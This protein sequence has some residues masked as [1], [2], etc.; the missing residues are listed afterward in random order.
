MELI[1]TGWTDEARAASLATRRAKAEARQRKREEMFERQHRDAG[2]NFVENWYPRGRDGGYEDPH[3][4]ETSADAPYGYVEGTKEP[5]KEPLYD[6]YGRPIVPRPKE[7][8]APG[9]MFSSKR[10]R[11]AKRDRLREWL[12]RVKAAEKEWG[13][14][15][16]KKEWMDKHPEATESDWEAYD[17][18]R[19]EEWKKRNPRS[20]AVDSRTGN[21]SGDRTG[22]CGPTKGNQRVMNTLILNRETFEMPNDGWYQI[23][24][25]GEF[26]HQPTG[27]VQV[28]DQAACDAMT[29]AF[30]QESEKSNFAGLLIDFD[31][32]SLDDK[33]KSEAAGWITELNNR[34]DGLWA[35]IRWSDIGEECV[36]G[37]R[38]RFLSPVWSQ[39]DCDD[40][41]N[42]R[43]RP[44][45]LLNAAVTNDPNLKGMMPLSNRSKMGKQ[46][47]EMGNSATT[48]GTE[49]FKWMLG[50]SPDERHCPSCE[51]LAGQVHTM[52]D[53][54]AAGVA[55]GSESL[56]CKGNCHCSLVKTDEPATGNQ[57]VVPL[58]KGDAGGDEQLSN[59]GWSDE[60]R[61]A[62]LA[63]RRAKAAAR[64]AGRAAEGGDAGD[65][66]RADPVPLDALGQFEDDGL[67]GMTPAAVDALTDQIRKKLSNNAPLTPVEEAFLQELIE[68]GYAGESDGDPVF[69]WGERRAVEEADREREERENSTEAIHERA[70]ELMTREGDG[71]LLTAEEST[72]LEQYL[73]IVGN[74]LHRTGVREFEQKATKEGALR[75]AGWSDS[76]RAASIQVRRAKA[77]ARQAGKDR[78]PGDGP[79]K[80]RP[81]RK[82]PPQ[83]LPPQVPVPG[84][85]MIWPGGSPYFDE[86]TGQYVYPL[87]QR[88]PNASPVPS[89]PPQFL[90][91]P[92]RPQSDDPLEWQHLGIPA[93]A[94]TLRGGDGGAQLPWQAGPQVAA[95]KARRRLVMQR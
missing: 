28:V 92:S 68:D 50:S 77:A 38:Y 26:P 21:R 78:T 94:Q 11:Q 47:S 59:A 61:E 75:N 57:T 56:Y 49:R 60:A 71:E 95:D 31:H 40:L 62:S 30:K 80:K 79:E 58:R 7:D 13:S 48:E 45:R 46:K 32:F 90:P 82:G 81:V 93:D 8:Y 65:G 67:D 73:Q 43:L 69:E 44:V 64:Q 55:P 87:P 84:A 29:N 86:S 39:R 53:W 66:D 83:T 51:A 74:R 24:P 54:D 52:A 34:D 15:G 6:I 19:L 4:G 27:V 12:D 42:G 89:G 9:R 33:L 25:L 18:K 63:V 16:K 85:G 17:Q 41:G 72:F 76:A 70:E 3:F 91:Y 88:P 37:G 35:K 20:E 5:R 1:N 2:R 14:F 22:R 23:A 10:E 36:K